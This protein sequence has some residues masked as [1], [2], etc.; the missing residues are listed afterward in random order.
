MNYV[1]GASGLVGTAMVEQICEQNL[2]SVLRN[3]YI[4]WS[5]T[6]RLKE[7]LLDMKIT[8]R[9]TFYYCSGLTNPKGNKNQMILVNCQI[10]LT[11]L[12]QS[13]ETG[14]R[15]VTFGSILENSRAQN[16][17]INTKKLFLYEA[18]NLTGLQNHKHFQLHT[19]YGIH[20]PKT[21]MLLGKILLHYRA[22][23]SWK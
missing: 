10:P 13:V 9:D 3:E 18:S 14:Y 7:F 12:K 19:V 2:V 11:L 20:P 5:S 6:E 4:S 1:L 16:P 8:E 23:L 17:Y 21:H 22:I 15:V